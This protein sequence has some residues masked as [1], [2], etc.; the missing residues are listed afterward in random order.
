MQSGIQHNVCKF[1]RMV[2][3]TGQAVK[4]FF[5]PPDVEGNEAC[6]FLSEEKVLTLQQSGKTSTKDKEDDEMLQAKYL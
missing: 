6:F 5:F 3:A 4:L 2:R 1:F